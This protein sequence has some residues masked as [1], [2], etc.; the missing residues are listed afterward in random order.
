MCK[1]IKPIIKVSKEDSSRIKKKLFELLCLFDDFCKKND[2]TYYL[3]GGTLLGAARHKGFIPWDDDIDVCMPIEDYQRLMAMDPKSVS[4]DTFIQSYKSDPEFLSGFMKI[5]ADNTIFKE[6]TSQHWNIHHGV[7]L[8]V[9]PIDGAPD[10]PKERN[11]FFKTLN[12][13]TYRLCDMW[14]SQRKG[15]KLFLAKGYH[16]LKS[17]RFFFL[18]CRKAAKKKIK[19]IEDHPYKDSKK[20]F[21]GFYGPGMKLYDRTDYQSPSYLEFEGRMFPCPTD[22]KHNL[23][24][25]FGDYMQLPPENEREGHHYVVE[26]KLN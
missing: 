4:D 24:T 21:I 1:D 3:L 19:Y 10:D 2:L 15:F 6:Y 17:G 13:L 16:T 12:H 18:P 14:V 11:R 7:Y 25:V 22:W 5:R 20:V 8:D 23:E 26:M 9:F